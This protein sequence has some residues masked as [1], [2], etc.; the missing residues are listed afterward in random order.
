MRN[1]FLS[2]YFF[3]FTPRL[4]KNNIKAV[5]I[6]KNPI[7]T[8]DM[9]DSL[10]NNINWPSLVRV[11]EWLPAPLGKYYLYFAHH[12]GKYIRL[13]YA[14]ALE[15]PWKIY[16]P[17]TLQLGGTSCIRHIASPDLH[18]DN[19]KQ[20]LRMYFHGPVPTRKIQASFVA[21][22]IDG[23]HFN[24]SPEILGNAYFRV[25]RWHDF[26]YAMSKKGLLYRSEN[27]LTDFE[28]GPNPF[29][30]LFSKSRVRH[31]AVQVRGD[32][33]HV[34]YSRVGDKPESILMSTIKLVPDWMIWKAS[35]PIIILKPEMDYEG[36][37]FPLKP[38]TMGMAKQSV[39]QLRDPA[40]YCEDERTYLLYSVAGEAGIAM[41]EINYDQ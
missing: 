24:V 20:E 36:V 21:T 19:E 32:T 15:G 26:Y 39:R 10:G 35:R 6:N 8:P 3:G 1:I 37:D 7:I 5:R 11:P 22:S 27:G 40:I 13:A 38:S 25:Y 31:V 4:F 17:G 14:D 16:E 41:A 29:N 33:L 30:T 28:I 34:Y 2:R 23:I 18:V 9:C 12:K